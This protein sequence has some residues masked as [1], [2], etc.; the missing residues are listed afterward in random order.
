MRVI[1]A[2]YWEVWGEPSKRSC[3]SVVRLD[4]GP[5][6]ETRAAV[7]RTPHDELCEVLCAPT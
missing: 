6:H 2:G 7:S 3:A 4:V 1:S 5:N